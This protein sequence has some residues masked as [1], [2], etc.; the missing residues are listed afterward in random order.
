MLTTM[1][2]ATVTTTT[3]NSQA[4]R[5]ELREGERLIGEARYT[6]AS[7]DDSARIFFHTEVD[8]AYQG[9]GLAARLAESALD[10]TLADGK[11]IVPICSYIAGYV[12]RHPEY[13]QHV[14]E[15]TAE[16]RAAVRAAGVDA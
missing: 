7:S 3:H 9:Q 6:P 8:D 13:A 5:F 16:H 15:P 4:R 12:R 2:A 14:D 10:E 11:R 1:D